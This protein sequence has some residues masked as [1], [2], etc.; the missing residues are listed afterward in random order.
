MNRNTLETKKSE[1]YN[2]LSLFS[3]EKSVIDNLVS[4]A[5][6]YPNFIHLNAKML[7]L[8][9]SLFNKYR[10]ESEQGLKQN[11]SS[12]SQEIANYFSKTSRRNVQVLP[13][14]QATVLRY[15]R[16]I[17]FLREQI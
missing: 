12:I 13:E 10:I 15:S 5:S 17:L 7:A 9:F 16:Y 3:L 2:E 14:Q 1:L 11:F 4:E 8:I 6:T